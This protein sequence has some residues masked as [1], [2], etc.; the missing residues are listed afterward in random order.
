MTDNLLKTKEDIIEN[1]LGFKRNTL[2]NEIKIS[3]V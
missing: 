1:E 2:S 3:L